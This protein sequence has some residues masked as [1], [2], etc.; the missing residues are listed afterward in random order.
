MVAASGVEEV[1][2]KN[3]FGGVVEDAV[4]RNV[5]AKPLP[6][7]EAILVVEGSRERARRMAGSIEEGI[8]LG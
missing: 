5:E 8:L 1:L 2:T 4:M 3:D 6:P 7:W